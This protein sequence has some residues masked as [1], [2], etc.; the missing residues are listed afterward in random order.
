[1]SVRAE[2]SRATAEV[3]QRMTARPAVTGRE[4]AVS[5]GH[6]LA[7]LAGM[8]LL[9]QGGNAIDAG[10]A[11]GLAL[12]VLQP[13]IVGVAGVAPIILYWAETGEVVTISGL[14]RWPRRASIRFFEERAGGELPFGVLRSVVPAALDAW[15]TALERYGTKSFEEVASAAL[16]LAA[17]G[18]PAHWLLCETVAEERDL[19]ARW[20]SSAAIFL[21]EGQ[22]PRVG[23][24]FRQT[25]L[26]RTLERLI[27]A[28]RRAGP[29]RRAGLEAVRAAFYDGPIAKEIIAFYDPEGGLL[30]A[31]DLRDFRVGV[32]PPVST[33]FRG[34]EV[35]SCGPWCQ[36][37]LLLEFLNLV[38]HEDLGG[39]GLNSPAYVHHLV[40]LM[41]LGFADR[42]AY[43]GDPE[44]VEVP[45]EDL[46]SKSYARE[47]WR[48][49]SAESAWPD[50]PPAGAVGADKAAKPARRSPAGRGGGRAALDTTYLS[51]V[52]RFGN[53][54][55]A[56]PSDGYATA[57][58]VPGLGFAVSP[59]GDQSW[60]DPA[61]PSS[62]EPWK[63]PRLTPN[64]A[65]VLKDGDLFMVFG[66][67]GGDVQCQAMLQVFLNVVE[68]GMDP[69]AAIEAPRFATASFPSSF[70]PHESRPGLV[71]LETDLKA[72]APALA[73]KGHRLELWPRW[74]WHAGG[75]CAI[76]ADREQG[77]LAAGADPRR[78]CYAMAW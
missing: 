49:V 63:R 25:D 8:R 15:L 34:Y 36:G 28:E 44:F 16:A 7:T 53:G 32:E 33:T 29:G 62:I 51:V 58:V 21:S 14:G 66:T 64:P 13:D 38:E 69:Q 71:K 37:P 55:S 43:F 50:M 47:R 2:Q 20:P 76:V 73:A 52:D 41:K 11:A 59:R 75:V 4:A 57:P 46:L 45:L 48:Q 54:F 22:A 17:E 31:R 56:T 72:A 65:L 5:T 23:E 60:L 12:G 74:H 26:A 6:P 70:Y 27:E 61:H 1:M 40:E 10:V 35:Y 77:H 24:R 30:S 67:P 9:D 18:F 3:T 39:R 78:E 19:Y 68:F 42:E